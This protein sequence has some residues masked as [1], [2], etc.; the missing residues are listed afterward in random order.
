VERESEREN[1]KN[2]ARRLS[3]IDDKMVQS[4]FER[5]I[6]KSE[7]RIGSEASERV[8]VRRGG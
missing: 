6:G 3:V 2:R 1:A 4:D 7:E 5:R 8:G